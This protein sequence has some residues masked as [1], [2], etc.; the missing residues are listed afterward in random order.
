M[1]FPYRNL[2]LTTTVLIL[3]A[4]FTQS[5][6]RNSEISIEETTGLQLDGLF[7]PERLVCQWGQIDFDLYQIEIYDIATNTL[8]VN[9][10]Q[11]KSKSGLHKYSERDKEHFPYSKLYPSIKKGGG[12]CNCIKEK[13][14]IRA[15]F[16]DTV[17]SKLIYYSKNYSRKGH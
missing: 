14:S 6:K 12:Y 15:V 2:I 9:S 5:C 10:L 16:I 1:R 17:N 3:C 4:T 8:D 13:E 11:K 7:N